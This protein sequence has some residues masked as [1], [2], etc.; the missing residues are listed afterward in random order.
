V[1]TTPLRIGGEEFEIEITLT[2][3]DEMG[4]RMLLGRSAIR[5]R[6]LVDPGKSFF[7]S[8]Q[9]S[10]DAEQGTDPT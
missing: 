4:F 10:P 2:S 7:H 3:R 8:A 5:R 1:I 9:P 6:F